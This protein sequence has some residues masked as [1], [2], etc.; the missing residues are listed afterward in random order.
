MVL[1]KQNSESGV[2]WFSAG[3]GI[4]DENMTAKWVKRPLDMDNAKDQYIPAPL[5]DNEVTHWGLSIINSKGKREIVGYFGDSYVRPEEQQVCKKH[6]KQKT[7]VQEFYVPY[8]V[9]SRY[10]VYFDNQIKDKK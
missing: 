4:I 1:Y 2:V 3:D 6:C 9:G 7:D 8:K 5:T 10:E